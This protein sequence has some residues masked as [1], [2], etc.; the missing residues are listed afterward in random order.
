MCVCGV[1]TAI[2]TAVYT[3]HMRDGGMAVYKKGWKDGVVF[4]NEGLCRWLGLFDGV[5]SKRLLLLFYAAVLSLALNFD[6]FKKSQQ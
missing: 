3:G 4:F 2:Y 5:L 6:Y 1:W